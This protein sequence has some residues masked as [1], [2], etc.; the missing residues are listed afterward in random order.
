MA[1]EELFLEKNG[2]RPD[3]RNVLVVLTDG[4]QKPA[5][6]KNESLAD[7]SKPLT[8]AK[9]EIMAVGFG[10]ASKSE[11]EK[12]ASSKQNVRFYTGT[13]AEALTKA[14]EGIIE[15]LCNCKYSISKKTF[16]TTKSLV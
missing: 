1:H 7:Y 16:I 11:L 4:K 10:S 9:V 12:I 6:P 3:V 13:A 14:V 8:D 15:K 2:D 5:L